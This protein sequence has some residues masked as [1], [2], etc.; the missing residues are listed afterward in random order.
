MARTN[1]YGSLGNGNNDNKIFLLIIVM[2]YF[3][4]DY[5][6]KPFG[7]LSLNWNELS[8]KCDAAAD[9][10]NADSLCEF[11]EFKQFRNDT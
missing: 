6:W 10:M 11:E 5:Q 4:Y 7:G 8:L 9:G 2:S 1:S 3:Y